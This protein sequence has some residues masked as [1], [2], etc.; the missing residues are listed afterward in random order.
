[1]TTRGRGYRSMQRRDFLK[2]G[3]AAGGLL[4]SNSVWSRVLA[5]PA[6]DTG[7]S[8]YGAL[9]DADPATGIQAPPGFTSREIARA[10][11]PVPGTT[12]LYP[13]FPDG[14]HVFPASNSFDGD[15]GWILVVNSENPPPAS[16]PV[17]GEAQDLLG[18]ASAIRFDGDGN[19]V[20]AYPV[21]S[22]TRSNCSG[23]ATPWGTWLSCEEFD[24]TE[25]V[26]DGVPLLAPAP[27]DAGRVWECDPTGQTPARAVEALGRFKHEAAAFDG[28]GRVYLT[29]DIGDG[30][31][32]RF[33][34]L[35]ANTRNT[36]ASLESGT[37]E[38]MTVPDGLPGVGGAPVPVGWTDPLDPSAANQSTR[39]QAHGQGAAVFD[40]G[41]GCWFAPEGPGP[42]G[43]VYFTTKGDDRVWAHD[44]GDQTLELVYP[45]PMVDSDDRVL[46]GVDNLIVSPHTGNV[47]VVE[48]GGNMEVVVIEDRPDLGGR[49]AAP[50]V[51]FTGPQHGLVEQPNPTPLPLESEV[52]GVTLVPDGTRMYFS[53]QRELVVGATYELRA[54]GG[55]R[56]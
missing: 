20:D 21:L 38:A 26:P 11:T 40:G 13:V 10:G 7:A 53:S 42:Q 35:P 2:A 54:P 50:F 22:G 48:D 15:D 1:M 28:L 41:E 36:P 17:L 5:A 47:Y 18:G 16:V 19:I 29:E 51:R 52:T 55:T 30:C 14:A 32:Y 12:S 44:T 3:L 46:S 49:F 24:N 34:P 25:H 43:V 31:L 45:G 23:G 39:L 8:S 56:F 9:R 6:N 27:S 37:L 33:R 4:V